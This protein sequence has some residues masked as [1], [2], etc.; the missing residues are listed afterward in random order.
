MMFMMTMP[1]TTSEIAAMPTATASKPPEMEFHR[2]TSEVA[3]FERE[4]VVL[5]GGGRGARPG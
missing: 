5:S 2:P 1:P 4:A 3:G